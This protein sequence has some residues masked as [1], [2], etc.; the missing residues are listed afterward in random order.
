MSYRDIVVKKPWGHEYLIY[1]NDDLGIWFLHIEKDQSTSMHCHPKKNTGLVVLDGSAE[2]SFLKNKIPLKGVDK[3]MIF[4]RRFHSTKALSTGGAYILEVEAP[5]DKHDLVR[6]Y[7]NYGR[8]DKP[9]EGKSHEYKKDDTH[10]WF[11]DPEGKKENIYKFC[12][13][14]IKTERIFNI[15]EFKNRP[16]EEAVVF[17]KGGLRSGDNSIVQPGII[18]KSYSRYLALFSGSSKSV[19]RA[20]ATMWQPNIP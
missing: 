10:S 1:E 15:E 11:E 4:S 3:V 20:S 8:S 7:D 6:L 12:N 16:Y 17:L 5:K 19:V 14:T 2:V 13:C 18:S 9:Y